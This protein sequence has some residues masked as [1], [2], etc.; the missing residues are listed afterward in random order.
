MLRRVLSAFFARR[1][2]SDV[3]L[4]TARKLI[5]LARLAHAQA[6]QRAASEPPAVRRL[7]EEAIANLEATERLE[8]GRAFDACLLRGIALRELGDL[9]AAH[10]AFQAAHRLRPGDA[11]AACE[12][13]FSWQCLGAT[14]RAIAAYGETI[15]RAPQHAHAHAGLALSL[16]GAGE[17]ARGWEEYEWRLRAPDAAAARQFPFPAWQGEPLAGRTLLVRSEQGVG[18]EILFA[19]CL[20]DLIAASGRCVVECSRRLAPLFRRSFPQATVFERDLAAGPVWTALPPIDLQVMAGSVPRFLRRRLEDFPGQPF[21]RPDPARAS[22]W[23][24]R[25]GATRGER[26]IGLAWSGGLPGTLRAA[27]SLQLDELAPLVATRGAR[28]V[29]LELLD[30]SEEIAAFRG[31]HGLEIASFKGLAVELDELAAV[32]SALDLVITVP[33]AVAHVAGAIGTSAWVIVPRVATWRYLW[34]GE[35]MPWYSSI[36]MLRRRADQDIGSFVALVGA[37]LERF[38]ASRG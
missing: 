2:P 17:F 29:S 28:F 25:L 27:R 30:R 21:L 26:L 10:R 4:R 9:E 1:G 37:E 16:L 32:V 7:Y 15:V 23:R 35:R 3:A 11:S 33:T 6:A 13:A 20:P 19:S 14:Q 18:D 12:L 24:P 8:P 38:L 34:A 22:W 36:R 31:R 5:E